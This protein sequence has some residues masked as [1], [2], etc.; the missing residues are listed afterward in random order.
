M[1]KS[2]LIKSDHTFVKLRP[3][4]ERFDGKTRLEPIDDDWFL[5]V[6]DND[7]RLD[8][9]RT[10][11]TVTLGFDHIHHWSTNPNL[12]ASTGFLH[13]NGHLILSGVMATFEPRE[14]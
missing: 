7:V 13:L 2:S 12:G 9:S 3:M 11:H 5:T 1:Q 8:L 4:A 6:K 14:R 10:G